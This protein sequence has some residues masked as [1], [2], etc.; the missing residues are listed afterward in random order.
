M[1]ILYRRCAGL[2]VHQKSISVCIRI[3]RG[4]ADLE[5]QTATFGTFTEDLE[6]LR[7]WLRQY[8]VKQVAMESTGVYWIPVWNVL[9]RKPARFELLLLNPHHVRA[10]PGCKTDTQ[11]CERIAELLQYGLVRASFVPPVSIRELRDLTRARVHVQQDRNRVINRIHRLLETSNI[12]L[13]SVLSN[14]VGKTGRSI[15]D[16]LAT[17]TLVKPE[18]FAALATHKRL[19]SKQE[20]LRKALRCD[21]SEHFRFLLSEL[22]SE[23]DHL[24]AKVALLDRRITE[25]MQPHEELLR[26]LCEIPGVRLLTA[27]A[28]VAEIGTDMTRFA[29]AAHLASWAGLCPGNS[30]SAGKRHS[31]RTRKGNS[32]LRR[33]LCQSAWAAARTHDSFLRAVFFRIARRS[34]LK[35]AA[36]ALAHRL[37]VIIYTMLRDGTHYREF[38][39][40]YF[41][42]L[43][44]ERA[45]QRLLRRLDRLGFDIVVMPRPAT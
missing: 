25:R 17:A 32:Y 4:R 36:I 6:R 29:D 23:L 20:D 11:D 26:R 18:S 2:D 45:A 33:A 21:R 16:A 40:D 13:A 35:K 14:I 15:L 9:E 24:D 19:K 1:K 34:G 5:M 43:H 31:G 8:K 3:A 39:G 10:L 42:R 38:G 41:D 27:W 30:E 22:L 44:P 7:D 37:L 28:V 12:K